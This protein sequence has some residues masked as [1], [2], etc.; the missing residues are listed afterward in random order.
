[1]P[2]NRVSFHYAHGFLNWYDLVY[3]PTGTLATISKE[4]HVRREQING[5]FIEA[6]H[7]SGNWYLGHFGD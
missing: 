2:D 7:L 1:M 6:S 3:D 4:E 5:Y